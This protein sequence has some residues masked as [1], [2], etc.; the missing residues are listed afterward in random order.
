VSV[1]LHKTQLS[2]VPGLIGSYWILPR[3]ASNDGIEPWT[4][5]RATF[6]W[7]APTQQAFSVPR[8]GCWRTGHSNPMDRL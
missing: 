4:H 6:V 5:E 3:T 8:G 2:A 1:P 7:P